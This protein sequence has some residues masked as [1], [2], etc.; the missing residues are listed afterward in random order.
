MQAVRAWR[1]VLIPTKQFQKQC[2]FLQ[3]LISYLLLLKTLLWP[4]LRNRSYQPGQAYV[5]WQSVPGVFFGFIRWPKNL[6]CFTVSLFFLVCCF[7]I[8][9]CIA[10]HVE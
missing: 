1:Q 2:F 6:A 10:G 7:S 3:G 4:G 5:S 8:S 9:I